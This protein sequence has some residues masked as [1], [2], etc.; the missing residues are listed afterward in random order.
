MLFQFLS[1]GA[2]T[3][4]DCRML[5]FLGTHGFL[6]LN[7]NVFWRENNLTRLIEKFEFN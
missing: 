2:E 3:L 6:I 1:V 7:F 4:Q 5:N